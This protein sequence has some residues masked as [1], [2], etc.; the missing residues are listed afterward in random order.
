MEMCTKSQNMQIKEL[1]NQHHL[2]VSK[3]PPALF[4]PSKTR[5][6]SACEGTLFFAG[7]AVFFAQHLL[8]IPLSSSLKMLDFLGK[9]CYL[10]AC[11]PAFPAEEKGASPWGPVSP[12]SGWEM[13]FLCFYAFHCFAEHAE[14]ELNAASSAWA[15][16][17][18]P[19]CV[20]SAP[21]A[22][23]QAPVCDGCCEHRCKSR[24]LFVSWHLFSPWTA[25]SCWRWGCCACRR[26]EEL[27]VASGC[28]REQIQRTS[29]ARKT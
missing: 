21:R 11:M 2:G 23:T 15:G 1:C 6:P 26:H 27:I 25:V 4:P 12:R 13:T 18:V 17:G 7:S 22:R 9:S 3:P 16:E 14:C 28:F 29:L 19:L 10:E 5:F 24:I 20:V 8:F